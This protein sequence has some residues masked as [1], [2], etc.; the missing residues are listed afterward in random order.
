MKWEIGKM[1]KVFKLGGG[2]RVIERER[3][4]RR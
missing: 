1:G 2:R 4:R 3:R